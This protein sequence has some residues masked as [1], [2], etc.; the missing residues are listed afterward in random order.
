MTKL[1]KI[2]AWY[3]TFEE[4]FVALLL[5]ASTLVC[6]YEVFM[7]YI[8][9]AP[10]KWSEEYIRYMMVWMVFLG[11]S[12]ASK[13]PHDLINFDL[14]YSKFSKTGRNIMDI[15]I[16]LIILLFCVTIFKTCLEWELHAFQYG[17]MSTAMHV[18]NWIP[19]SLC[20]FPFSCFLCA[21][22]SIP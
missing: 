9:T 5:L 6:C 12:V 21:F 1:K 3:N 2:G 7:R 13:N 14:L 17:G 4:Y 16:N 8:L 20:R 11:I 15:I 18:P 10:T 19:E 22:L